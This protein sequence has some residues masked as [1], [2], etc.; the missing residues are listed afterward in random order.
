MPLG[1]SVNL[2]YLAALDNLSSINYGTWERQQSQ[3]FL[4]LV[5]WEDRLETSSSQVS[6]TPM[7]KSLSDTNKSEC[8][9]IF[10]APLCNVCQHSEWSFN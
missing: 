2:N 3:C 6:L 1:V 8:Y 4:R 9:C 7:G 5:Y 10:A